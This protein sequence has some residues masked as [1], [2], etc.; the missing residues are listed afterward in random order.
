MRHMTI[1]FDRTEEATMQELQGITWDHPRGLAPIRATAVAFAREH[2]D[3][4]I[5]WTVRSLHAF[6]A[7]P[8]TDMVDRY[9]LLV[10]DH[11]FVGVAAQHGYLL[12]LDDYLPAAF[13]AAQAGQSVGPSHRSYAYAGHQWA[14]AIDAAAQV[15]AYR[16]DLLTAADAPVPRTWSDVLTLA[17]RRAGPRVALPLKPV[18]AISCFFTLCANA[19][20]PACHDITRLVGRTTGRMALDLLRRVAA[21]Y[22][23]SLNLNPPETLDRMAGSDEIVYAPLIFGYSN[24][25]R[26]G[27]ARHLVRFTNIPL[28]TDGGR[29]RGALLGGAGLAL[30]ASCRDIPRACAYAEWV[31]SADCQRTLYVETGGQPG[32]RVAW[33]DTAVNAATSNFFRDT[34]ETLDLSYLRPRYPGFAVFQDEAGQALNEWLRGTGTADNLLEHLDELYI[35][36]HARE[37]EA[38]PT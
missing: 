2:S 5:T 11:P 33:T 21:A 1:V 16:P 37:R 31:A 34:L 7:Q 26:P 32:N 14:L 12:P 20:E 23:D 25:A 30:S 38:N 29:P 15:S 6:G 36:N 19:G 8:L 13:L 9:D 10:I 4:H 3:V 18:D 17:D 35:E 27:Y 24:Y 22:P 28:A